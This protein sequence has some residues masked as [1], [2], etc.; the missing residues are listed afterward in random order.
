M[1]LNNKNNEC[2]T[3]SAKRRKNN[4]QRQREGNEKTLR[5]DIARGIGIVK[6]EW[7]SHVLRRTS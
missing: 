1:V 4:A 2:L 5:Q 6:S 7:V 3:N